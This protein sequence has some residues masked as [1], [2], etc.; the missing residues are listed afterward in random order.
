MKTTVESEQK[1]KR[2]ADPAAQRAG[3][4]PGAA[5]A[6]YLQRLQRAIGNSGVQRVV[7]KR[8]AGGMGA[9]TV[10]ELGRVRRVPASARGRAAVVQ[11]DDDEEADHGTVTIEEPASDPYS[12]SGTTLS[13]V[14]SQL[15]PEEWGRCRYHYD[16]TYDTTNGRA[17]RVN[18]TLRLQIRMPVWEEGRDQASPEAQAE[19]DRMIAAL[20]AHE[21]HHAEIARGW[22]QTFQDRML[23]VR[24]GNLAARHAQVLGQVNERQDAYDTQT[25]HGQSEGVSLD[26]SIDQDESEGEEGA[27][28]GGEVEEEGEVGVEE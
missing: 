15:D 13:E 4:A 26:L 5:P 14:F 7:E 25:T 27:E 21:E 3:G 22:A 1:R 8:L 18:I 2:D 17:T 28:G 19:W 20:Q 12:V 11:R 10:H 24:E 23:G 9:R 16:Y 6:A